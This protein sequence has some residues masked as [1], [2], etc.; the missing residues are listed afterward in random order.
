MIGAE[1]RRRSNDYD[2]EHLRTF[3]QAS[4]I[5]AMGT[6]DDLL[7]PGKT[8]IW[9]TLVDFHSHGANVQDD[10]PEAMLAA[11]GYME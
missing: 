2:I 6:L 4:C 1:E 10:D 9:R 3:V 11:T 7:G 5:A 8:A